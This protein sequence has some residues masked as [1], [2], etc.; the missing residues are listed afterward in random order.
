MQV[1]VQEHLLGSAMEHAAKE[2]RTEDVE[3]GLSEVGEHNHGYLY[4]KRLAV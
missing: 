3:G 2:G 1:I 4:Q